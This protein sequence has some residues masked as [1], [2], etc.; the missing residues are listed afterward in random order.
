MTTVIH[1]R[2]TWSGNTYRQFDALFQQNIY[3]KNRHWKLLPAVPLRM[4]SDGTKIIITMLDHIIRWLRE[5]NGGW[6]E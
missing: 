6:W 3:L 4:T 5:T 1:S 2:T